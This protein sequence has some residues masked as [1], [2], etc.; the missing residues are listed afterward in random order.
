[1]ILMSLLPLFNIEVLLP[2]EIVA[3]KSPI[4]SISF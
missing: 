4:I 2:Q 3:I 1:M